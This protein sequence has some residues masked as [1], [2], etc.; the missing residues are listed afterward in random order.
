MTDPQEFADAASSMRVVRGTPDDAELA[1]LVAGMV[2]MASA[3]HEE[4]DPGA[5]TAA[6]M[7]RIRTMRG[8]RVIGP[9]GR[10]PS[11][12]RHSLR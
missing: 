8:R 1:A 9:L 7:D 6:W 3:A 11:A 4:A 2:A 5:P 10:G 12:W